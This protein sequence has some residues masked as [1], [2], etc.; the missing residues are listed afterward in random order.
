MLPII[1]RVAKPMDRRRITV[2]EFVECPDRPAF[3]YIKLV[4]KEK[5]FLF[6]FC[7]QQFDE[8]VQIDPVAPAMIKGSCARREIDWY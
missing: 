4:W 6:D 8:S 5:R 2:V 3:A 1:C 7:G